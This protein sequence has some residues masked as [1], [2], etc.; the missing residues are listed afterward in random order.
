MGPHPLEIVY[1]RQMIA[2]QIVKS[3]LEQEDPKEFISDTPGIYDDAI[4][5]VTA[6]FMELYNQGFIK[7][8]RHADEKVN[9]LTQDVCAE[10]DLNDNDD[11][12]AIITPLYAMTAKLFPGD[13]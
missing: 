8:P 6:Q 3:L 12:E 4:E 2:S 1:S 10:L 5:Q 7:G 9:E 11:F 13:W